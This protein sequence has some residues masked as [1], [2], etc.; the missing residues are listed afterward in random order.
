MAQKSA[1]Q[2]KFSRPSLRLLDLT[3]LLAATAPIILEHKGHPVSLV[4]GADAGLFE[5]RR[6]DEDVL[7]A[8]LRLDEAVTLGRVE[9]FHRTSDAHVGIP[10]PKESVDRPVVFRAARSALY[11]RRGKANRPLG[12]Q[13][14]RNLED[15]PSDG[16]VHRLRR[17]MGQDR[18]GSKANRRARASPRARTTVIRLAKRAPETLPSGRA[19]RQGG[20]HQDGEAFGLGGAEL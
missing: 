18:G 3:G 1:P 8:V 19:L 10:F 4:Q 2:F 14:N 7:A 11:L 13:Q 12:K 15:V 6:V 16:G 20:I 9:K 5:R 17:Y